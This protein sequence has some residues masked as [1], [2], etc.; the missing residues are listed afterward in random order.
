MIFLLSDFTMNKSF[1][2][3]TVGTRSL[4]ELWIR[5]CELS[6]QMPSHQGIRWS[7]H[8]SKGAYQF[9]GCYE[10]F[11]LLQGSFT[12]N[13]KVYLVRYLILF[14]KNGCLFLCL[15]P[16]LWHTFLK[17]YNWTEFSY[18]TL[19]KFVISFIKKWNLFYLVS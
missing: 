18:I 7:V 1:F 11:S 2:F 16:Q 6:K 10:A 3:F 13:I 8:K 19:K 9:C 15:L 12:F 14:I 4:A 17:F 5:L